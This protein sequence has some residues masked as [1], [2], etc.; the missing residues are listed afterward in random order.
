[1]GRFSTFEDVERDGVID[2]ASEELQQRYPD[3]KGYKIGE[4]EVFET[5]LTTLRQFGE[6]GILPNKDYG[7]LGSQKCD[8]LIIRRLP[9]AHSVAIGEHKKPGVIT[10]SNWKVLAKDLIDTKCHP[11]ETLIGY[12]TDGI[13]TRWINGQ[14]SEVIEIYRED[15]KAMPQTVDFKD[16]AFVAEISYIINNFDP[17]Y[18]RVRA[19][20]NANPDLLAKEVWQTIWRLKADRPEDCL[21]TFVELFVFKFLDDLGLLKKDQNG[22]DV[23]LAHVMSLDREI[24]YRYYD[25]TI[26]PHIKEMFPA[27]KDGYSIIN[28]IVLQASNRDHNIIFY[29]I[30]K[31]FIKFGTLKN[32]DPEFKTRL[33][34]SFLQESKTTTT[35]GQFFTP[36]KVVSAINDMA[37]AN[38]LP[39][40]K[41]ICDPASGV[42]G[43]I[44]EQ[45]ARDLD[46][47]WKLG[48]NRM[49]PVHK[50]H[51]YEIVPKTA[52]LAKANAL[53]HCGDLLADQ[54]A[55]IKAFAKWLNEVFVCKDKTSLGSLEEMF[56]EKFDLIMTNPPFVVSGS[57]DIG[58]LIKSN[59]K[60]STY[61]GRKYSGVEGLFIQFIVQSLK[62]NGEAWVLLPETFFL[63]TTDQILRSWILKKCFLDLLAILPAR[64]FFN[65]P[66]RAV[67]VHMKKRPKEISDSALAKQLEEERVLLFAVSE[68]GETRDAKR[69]PCESD[70]PLLVECY[71]QFAAGKNPDASTKRAAVAKAID[72]F[73][74]TSVNLRHCWE[75]SVAKD[76]GLL[77]A[78]EDPLEAKKVLDVRM[79]TLEAAAREWLATGAKKTS[80]RNPDAWKRVNLGDEALFKLIIG[81]R[82][83]KKNIYQNRQG[84]PLFSANIRNPFGFVHTANAGNLKFGGCLWSIDSDFDC[85]GVAAGESYSITD[86]CGQVEICS[87]QIDPHYL[88]RQIRQSGF[89][90]GFNRDYRPSLGIMATLELDLP[91]NNKGEFD[92]VIMQ[93]WTAF[94]EEIDRVGEDLEK[95]MA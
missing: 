38:A 7:A 64:T 62:R 25:S 68:I 67:I 77:G 18:S 49:V 27:G 78:D 69:L 41:E 91:A 51:A 58:K 40:G 12:L 84:V 92:L 32:T 50:W 14:A 34:E 2:M 85:R 75:K 56:K 60:R 42:G 94:Q 36:R 31:K 5:Q 43:F 23:R 74:K 10:N 61:F 87:D 79:K 59:N 1:M 65:T 83:L 70:L 13:H 89:D 37:R 22:A 44:L 16:K 21:A 35:F 20:I 86:H 95:L 26:R 66:K 17:I 45:M 54:P 88:A 6:H 3:G 71:L 9:V 15:G 33:Y 81:K 55:R 39:G 28:G 11:T 76:I 48:G 4:F 29:E 63:R 90:Q 46:T 53:V 19:K 24:S 57:A 72:L 8:S 73:G 30:L 52:I 80:P 47:Q 93:E 82:V